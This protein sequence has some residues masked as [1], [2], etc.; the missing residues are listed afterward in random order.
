[1][2]KTELENHVVIIRWDRF[3]KFVATQ[4][5]N[6]GKRICVVTRDPANREV[7][8]AEFADEQIDVLCFDYENLD[9]LRKAGIEKCSMALIN[10]AEDTEKLIYILKLKRAFPD[11][12][13][14][15]P[16]ENPNLK[17]TFMHA[18]VV[19]PLSKDEIVSKLFASYLF[20]K[21]VAAYV[22]DLLS[23][24]VDENDYDIQQY[25][26]IAKNPLAGKSY[27][28]A[29]V[30]LK[31]EYNAVLI[32]MT[33]VNGKARNLLKNPPDE[34]IIELNDYLIIILNGKTAQGV[35]EVF[36]IEEGI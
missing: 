12:Q 6:A 21:D 32:G 5:I 25:R 13:I 9:N 3:A 26:V 31:K 16:I 30:K 4:I 20:E 7:I 35:E 11:V 29:F 36:G 15:A 19:H 34:T 2:D 23:T 18:G 10:L 14:V 28:E 8:A 33:K 22:N 1:M 27:G 24:A 17:D